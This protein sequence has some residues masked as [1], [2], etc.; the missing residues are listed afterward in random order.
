[1]NLNRSIFLVLILAL[2]LPAFAA[3]NP[4]PDAITGTHLAGVPSLKSG[5]SAKIS[6]Q[7]GALQIE[8]KTGPMT[9][10][11]LTS[12]E[13]V[14]A[15]TE[16]TQSGGKVGKAAK[17]GAMAAPYDTGAVLKLILRVKIDLLTVLYRGDNGDLHS[18]LLTVTKGKAEGLR[19]QMISGGA[20]VKE[21]KA[22]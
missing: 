18:V 15:G 21:G 16:V 5:A 20:H 22:E 10:V 7:N 17:V 14:Y 1:M 12:V 13:D 2:A 11:K 6:I 4:S 8:G 9:V 19:S 3:D